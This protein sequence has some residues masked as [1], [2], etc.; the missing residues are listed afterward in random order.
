MLFACH[1]GKMGPMAKR[2]GKSKSRIKHWHNRY[3]M[4]DEE[5]A[6]H[7]KRQR[8][9]K[10]EVRN[11]PPRKLLTGKE[12]LD[13][14]P[15]AEGMVVG[16]Y[17]GGVAVRCDGRDVLCMVAKNFRP[18]EG[19]TALT[20]GDIV[21]IAITR[22]GHADG[23]QQDMDRTD[24]MILD[25]AQRRTALSRPQPRSQKRRDEFGGDVFEKVIAANI[26]VLMIVV[27]ARQPKFRR[28]LVDRFLICAQRGELKP[29]LVVNKIDIADIDHHQLE[30]IAA[31]GVQIVKVSA[32]TGAG[33]DQLAE[34]IKGQ[35]SI[36]AG[37]SGVG[38]TSLINRLLPGT[39]ARTRAVRMV[40]ERGRHTTS[41]T[42]IYELP[43][44]GIILDT[45]GIRE[46]GLAIAPSQLPWYFPEFE[47][48]SPQCHYN[49]CTHTHE[50]DCA[51]VDAVEN[52][53]I[54]IMRYESYLKMLDTMEDS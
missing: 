44:G 35:K 51:V 1:D 6:I 14:L 49:N 43:N 15:R 9:V 28:G 24:A 11:L 23:Q 20:I 46:L 33:V 27:A 40:D 53:D 38:K 31:L 26:D 39:D 29:M 36:F 25:R 7:A 17:P 42:K 21:T 32:E 47:P 3:T 54:P 12:E 52:G 22:D 45:P 37:P 50:P 5:S 48:F 2:K 30:D 8:L 13:A 4:G 34:S 19:T 10:K 18:P 16:L 41:A